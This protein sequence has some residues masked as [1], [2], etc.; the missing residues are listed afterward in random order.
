MKTLS[1]E[2]ILLLV[3]VLAFISIQAD[4]KKDPPPDDPPEEPTYTCTSN[5]TDGCMDDWKTI[6]TADGDY[7]EPMGG[8]LQ[9]LNELS[10]LPPAAGGPGPVTCDT[11]TDCVQGKYAARLTSKNFHL[12]EGV[13][14]FIPGYVGASVLDIPGATIHLGKPYALRPQ[15]LQAYYKY[16]P[17][18]SDSAMIQITLTKY[19]VALSK[20]DTIVNDRIFVKSAVASYTLFDH[21]LNYLDPTAVPDTMALIFAAS[22]GIDFNDLQGCAGQIGSTLW[23]DDV[24][25]IFP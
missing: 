15:K 1:F 14:I 8:Y 23:V 13:D 2:R 16:T 21:T 25:F 19:N 22:G 6:S 3:G 10:S 11:V 7:M 4:C 17:S 18:G 9:T 20:R 24:K 12:M 5:V